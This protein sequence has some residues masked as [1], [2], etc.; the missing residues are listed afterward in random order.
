MLI[1]NSV[2]EVSK[3]EKIDSFTLIMRATGI[4]L[5]A[6]LIFLQYK[7]PA[8]VYKYHASLLTTC[9]RPDQIPFLA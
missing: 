2:N 8:K 1:G 4:S 7:F 5:H 9:M 6:L 3:E